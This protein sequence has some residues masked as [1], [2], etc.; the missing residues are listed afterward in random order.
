MGPNQ[1]RTPLWLY[2]ALDI[3]YGVVTT[4]LFTTS[5]AFL[6][7]RAGMSIGEIGSTVALMQVP[8]TFYFL[9]A[10][11]VDFFFRRKVWAALVGIL[12]G[13]LAGAG[14]VILNTHLRLAILLIFFGSAMATLVSAASGGMM[15]SLLTK[16]EKA[17]VGGWIQGGNLGAGSI[18]GGIILLLAAHHG[19]A[20]LAL[21]ILAG[22]V[23]TALT[24]L[25]VHEPH[26]EKHAEKLG[27]TFKDMGRELTQMFF[28]WKN[29]PGMLVLAS[30]IGTGA[31]Q[32]LM[33]GLTHEYGATGTQL[34]FA[35][36][37]GGGIATAIGS[38]C[39]ILWPA[40]WNRMV[41]YMGSAAL[42]M[43][44]TG[45]VALGPVA[46]WVLITGLICSNF[47]TGLC[48]GTYTGLVLQTMGEGGRRQSTRY[49]LLNAIGN[50]PV[51]YMVFLCGRVGDHFGPTYGPRVI[52]GFDAL[53]NL[54]AIA[55]FTL[56]WQTRGKRQ[57]TT[58][59]LAA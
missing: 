52:A 47:A 12:S 55:V 30:P 42:Y 17:K 6:L 5:I 11:I 32:S 44:V 10:P 49:T 39:A 2:A 14:L 34:A 40:K 4:G 24:A 3:P 7:R 22:C 29:L 54:A 33:G 37:F 45:G 16:E 38:L 13:V 9:Y 19:N 35:N 1:K 21:V 27:A 20:L 48:Y 25:A 31:M 58:I 36:G 41:P 53:T 50:L 51:V 15:G 8:I 28:N 56:W 18:A 23:P 46:P 57:D 26:R 43:L 59:T